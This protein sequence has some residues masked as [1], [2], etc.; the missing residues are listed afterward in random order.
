MEHIETLRA[1]WGQ[2]DIN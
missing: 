1:D 2:R